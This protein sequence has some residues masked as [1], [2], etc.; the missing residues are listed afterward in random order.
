M[1]L[2]NRLLEKKFTI[3]KKW[4]DV[5]VETYPSETANFLKN[6]KNRFTNPVGYTIYEG[7]EHIFEELLNGIDSD[8]IS[9]FLEN[10]IRIRAIEN[11]TPSQAIAFLFFLKK[12]IREELKGGPLL[13]QVQDH[14][15][16]GKELSEELLALDSQIDKLALLSFDIYMKCREKIYELKANEV[17]NMT[18]RLLKR[19][20]LVSVP[21]EE[22]DKK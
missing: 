3:L 22:K 6:Q 14:S 12:V 2:K 16:Q 8:R 4:F 17:K 10:I 1:D 21:Q 11:L 19:A 9:P 18:Y 15:G 13:N 5:I 20:N 7:I